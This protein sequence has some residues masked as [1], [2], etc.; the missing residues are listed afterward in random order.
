MSSYKSTSTFLGRS[1]IEMLGVLAIIGVLSIGSIS[2]FRIARAK[3]TANT[4]LSDV[5]LVSSDLLPRLETLENVNAGTQI[6]DLASSPKTD[7]QAWHCPGGMEVLINDVPED[8]CDKIIKM[9][10]IKGIPSFGA[11]ANNTASC[12]GN[13][14]RS[15]CESTNQIV[16]S[17]GEYRRPC[18]TQFC[19][20]G[21]TYCAYSNGSC[22]ETCDAI[23]CLGT[24]PDCVSLG[25]SDNT[26]VDGWILGTTRM[27]WWSANAWCSAQ[28][29]SLASAGDIS[30][31]AASFSGQVW[32]SESTGE[33][34]TANSAILGSTPSITDDS[35]KNNSF[36][37]LCH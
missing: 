23:T 35:N 29:K 28:N 34:C 15:G 22:E 31:I 20:S 14:F 3:T 32:L 25:G 26:T 13:L 8:V 7:I 11:L 12:S 18:G 33:G 36:F 9:D 27:N 24:S 10:S 30:A 4:I 2:G 17:L 16:F 5:M 6:T 37:P 1:M 21:V 19:E